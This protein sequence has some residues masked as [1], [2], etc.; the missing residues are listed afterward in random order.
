VFAE[1]ARRITA[2]ESAVT[3]VYP[4]AVTAVNHAFR[5][6]ERGLDDMFRRPPAPGSEP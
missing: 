1:I 3:A 4:F 2:G 6:L 5:W